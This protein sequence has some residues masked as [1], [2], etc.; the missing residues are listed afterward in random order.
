MAY[1][2]GT[3][4]DRRPN[5]ENPRTDRK[6][7]FFSFHLTSM[8]KKTGE[9]INNKKKSPLRER[10]KKFLRKLHHLKFLREPYPKRLC[11]TCLDALFVESRCA[12]VEAIPAPAT[13]RPTQP[14]RARQNQQSSGSAWPTHLRLHN[15][16]VGKYFKGFECQTNGSKIS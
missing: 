14:D 15:P 2:G 6:Q 4:T 3:C 10:E 16:T 9:K 8:K 5:S 1:R 11:T 13:H 7:F 12:S